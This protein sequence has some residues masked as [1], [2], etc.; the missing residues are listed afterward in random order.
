MPE[1][2]RNI[3]VSFLHN[4]DTRNSVHPEADLPK[5]RWQQDYGTTSILVTVTCKEFKSV[6]SSIII[7]IMMAMATA[8]AMGIQVVGAVVAEV[9]GAMAVAVVAVAAAAAAVTVVAGEV[10]EMKM[11]NTLQIKTTRNEMYNSNEF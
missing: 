4:S 1:A 8:L 3:D 10:V 5:C 6:N 9:V 11:K 2:V 7:T